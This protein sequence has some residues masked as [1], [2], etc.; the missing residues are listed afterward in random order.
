VVRAGDSL[1]FEVSPGPRFDVGAVYLTGV[2]ADIERAVAKAIGTKP[3]EPLDEPTFERDLL[4]ISAELWE[5]GYLDAKVGTPKITRV[6]SRLDI[7]I[8]VELGQVFH[9]GS[10]QLGGDMQ[11][12][13]AGLARGDLASRSRMMAISEQ[14][15]KR[16]GDGVR[17][18]L[19]TKLDREHSVAD[20]TFEVTWKKP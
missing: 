8:H 4:V 11:G 5:R 19:R 18:E 12:P 1:C 7:A 9:V 16:F 2:P 15:E 13:V 20:L 3:G 14:L 10:V 17:V 6:T